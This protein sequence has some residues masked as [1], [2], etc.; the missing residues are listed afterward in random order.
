MI[1]FP[2]MWVKKQTN[3]VAL[4]C[5]RGTGAYEKIGTYNCIPAEDKRLN[6][7]VGPEERTYKIKHIYKDKEIGY[8][9]PEWKII[10]NIHQQI[11]ILQ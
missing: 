5:K 7:T 9:S 10:A 1:V 4:Y 11:Y 2:A 3:G 6:L 8:F